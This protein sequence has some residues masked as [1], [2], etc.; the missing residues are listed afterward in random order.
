MTAKRTAKPTI[1]RTMTAIATEGRHVE[2]ERRCPPPSGPRPAHA[3]SVATSCFRIRTRRH[4]DAHDGCDRPRLSTPADLDFPCARGPARRGCLYVTA[5][6]RRL[7]PRLAFR[8]TPAP[9]ACAGAAAPV[10]T[11]DKIRKGE[12]VATFAAR[13]APDF[14]DLLALNPR[15]DL[16]RCARGRSCAFVSAD[17][18]RRRPPR[19]TGG[20]ALLPRPRRTS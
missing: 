13:H 8:D 18:A 14:G 1:T 6:A 19:G 11:M 7:V 2:S 10:Q 17:R 15:V 20:R 3:R 4:V 16:L 9:S 12:S 5:L